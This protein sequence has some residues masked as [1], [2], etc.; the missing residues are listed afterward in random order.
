[1]LHTVA[2]DLFGLVP[3]SRD[4]LVASAFRVAPVLCSRD[5]LVASAFRVP[6]VLCSPVASYLFGLV[7]CSPGLLAQ[8]VFSFSSFDKDDCGKNYLHATAIRRN[9]LKTFD[10]CPTS[11]DDYICTMDLHDSSTM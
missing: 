7:L 1:M 3:C 4:L 11:P 9:S 2:Y 6:P 5:L 8:K 10:A